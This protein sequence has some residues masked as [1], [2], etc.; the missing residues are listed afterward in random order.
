MTVVLGLALLLGLGSRHA[1]R[2]GGS[3]PLLLG[4]SLC[5]RPRESPASG[6]CRHVSMVLRAVTALPGPSGDG[7]PLERRTVG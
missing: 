4:C 6:P 3:F 5:R 7:L 1:A 2:V